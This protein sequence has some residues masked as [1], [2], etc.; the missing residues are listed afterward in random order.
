M[1][2]IGSPAAIRSKHV[3]D[4]VAAFPSDR[5]PLLPVIF[6]SG[7][8]DETEVP[9]WAA[10]VNGLAVGRCLA[11]DLERGTPSESVVDRVEHAV[12]N[13]RQTQRVRRTGYGAM[14][15]IALAAAATVSAGWSLDRTRGELKEAAQQRGAAARQRDDEAARG[16]ELGQ[17]N[18]ELTK[19]EQRLQEQIRAELKRFDEIKREA[20]EQAR[21]RKAQIAATDQVW[22]VVHRATD[23]YQTLFSQ[24]EVCTP[25]S[26]PSTLTVFYRIDHT[27]LSPAAMKHLDTFVTCYG[28]LANPPPLTIEGHVSDTATDDGLAVGV[29]S[30]ATE[31]YGLALGERM[32]AGTR[33]YL[34]TAGIPV[35]QLRTV[36]YGKER[37]RFGDALEILNN[38]VQISVS[39]PR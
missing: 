27:D 7:D 5:R 35:A 3:Q 9:A 29:P 38:R 39:S 4:E 6:L 34:R 16:A 15:V 17:K 2:V 37:P 14:A 30:K 36:S 23:A 18:H 24:L 8:T 11:S 20:D 13:Q 12:G 26:L 28:R 22:G 33:D 19:T 1:V 32:A 10:L 21:G 25:E 31:E